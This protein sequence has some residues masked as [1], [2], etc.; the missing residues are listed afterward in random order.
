M[1]PP[2]ETTDG[3]DAPAPADTPETTAPPAEAQRPTLRARLAR[4]RVLVGASA[5]AA[6]LV[7]LW[8]LLPGDGRP[9]DAGRVDA[10]AASARAQW[11]AMMRRSPAALGSAGV[12]DTL[13][14]GDAQRE[15]GRYADYYAFT[16]RDSA[17]FTVV[18]SSADFAP[19]IAV[20]RPDG[21]TVA[22]STLLRTDSRA[23]VADLRGP[24]RFEIVVTSRDVGA[25][26]V[27]DLTAGASLAA[28]TLYVDD[29]PRGDTLGLGAGEL[30]A[31]HFERIYG[32]VTASDA[33]VAISVVSADFLPRVSLIGPTGEVEGNW[34]TIERVAGDS[35]A[36]VVLRY[37]PGWDAPYRLV[38]SSERAG[39]RGAFAV[40]ART[41]TPR[42]IA[43]DGRPIDGHLGDD[44]WLEGY[45]YVDT[46]RFRVRDGVRTSVRVSSSDV[47][48]AFRLFRVDR[49]DDR[50]A[51]ADAN[52]R[53]AMS[54]QAEAALAA[55]DY[56]LEVTSGGTPADTLHAQ[57]GAYTLTV[58]QIAPTPPPRPAAP[59]RPPAA[60]A[61]SLESRVFGVSGERTGS[62][63]GSTFGVGATQVALSY[64]GGRTRVQVSISVRSVDYTGA[65]AAWSSFA[66]K[67][68]LVDDDGRRYTSSTSESASPSGERAE[69]GTV[70]RGT[71]VF[72]ARGA[73]T[74]Q[75]RFVL[76]ASIGASSVSLPLTVP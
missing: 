57:G 50:E 18:V 45:R 14:P 30:R 43:A 40:E 76:V 51:V 66:S 61:E 33:P 42:A 21:V 29:A 72:Y 34:R 5:A 9:T 24:G 27:Y 62:S 32:V 28:D 12:R 65:W 4:R 60:P 10:E 13:G 26:G 8:M 39:A 64:P 74:G 41:L 55:G 46:Y 69:P 6:L 59:V 2:P 7:G 19:D 47:P 38:V 68:Y 75:R 17:A 44:S 22:A 63:G 3:P 25:T 49:R 52:P 70:R 71:V 16:S 37:L 11:A 58:R 53:G 73:L 35:L 15:D 1:P 23:E 20:R 36:G 54:V 67:S 31:G 48:P 56:V